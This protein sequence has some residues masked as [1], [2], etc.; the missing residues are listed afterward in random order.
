MIKVSWKK[1]EKLSLNIA[2]IIR[3]QKIPYDC[4]IGISRSGWIPAVIIAHNLG[5]REL[6]SICIKRN[7]TD[8]INSETVSPQI[9]DIG[10]MT[11]KYLNWIV[12]D[13]IVGSGETIKF[14]RN[15]F[16]LPNRSIFVA[17]LFF[18]SQNGDINQINKLVNYYAKEEQEWIRFP[19]E[20][21][22]INR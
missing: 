16:S 5:V 4:I 6:T 11:K 12:I 17:S 10:L 3:E 22:I 1:I 13:D 21:E 7:K 9:I 20:T 8:E 15:K 19:W 2:K 18:N 14:I